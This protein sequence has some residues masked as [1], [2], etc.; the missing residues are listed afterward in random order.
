MIPSKSGFLN[1]EFE[2]KEQPSQT[3]KMH[4]GGDIV[5]G[6]VDAQ[7][8]MEADN[9]PDFKHREVPVYHLSLVVWNR[10]VRFVWGAG[11][12]GLPGIG[13][14][15]YGSAACRFAYYGCD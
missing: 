3:Y 11:Y 13:A 15:Y 5:Q 7:A 6:F 2:V 12:V 10:N 8:A 14:A 4:L 9:F 1:Q